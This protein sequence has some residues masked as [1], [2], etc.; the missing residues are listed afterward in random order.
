[1]PRHPRENQWPVGRTGVNNKEQAKH[2]KHIL[3]Q[4]QHSEFIGI[5]VTDA[6]DLSL[7]FWKW[8]HSFKQQSFYA[9]RLQQTNQA[10]HATKQSSIVWT[11]V[12]DQQTKTLTSLQLRDCEVSLFSMLSR[13]LF[14]QHCKE[15]VTSSGLTNKNC[16]AFSFFCT[17]KE[18]SHA[19][20]I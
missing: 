11:G 4:Q 12:C 14:E 10:P 6:A 20:L 5:T 17:I 8:F 7:H 2:C 9:F 16:F 18:R 13:T 3:S 1:V 19:H 15:S